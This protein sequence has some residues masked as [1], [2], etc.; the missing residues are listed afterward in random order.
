[1]LKELEI[2]EYIAPKTP[3]PLIDV[4]SPG[5][6]LKGH[7]PGAVNI[8]LFSNDERAHVGTVYKQQ[9]KEKAIE[10]GY[11][12][13]NPKLDDFIK[14]AREVAPDLNVVVHC[15]RG[16]MRSQSFAKHLNDN[17]FYASII[18]GGY[19]SYRNI[20]LNG[21][22]DDFRLLVLGGYTGSGK[23]P[24]LLRLKELGHQVI[25]LEGLAN[26]KGSAFGSIG[27]LPQPTPEQFENNLYWEWKDLD[28]S[29][30]IWLEDESNN[31]GH[32]AIQLQLFLKMRDAELL[33]LDIPKEK[34][35][36]HLI[37]DYDVHQ[38]DLLAEALERITKR[39]GGDRTRKAM[40]YLDNKDFYNVAII[41]L[42][43]Y[44]KYY[45]KGMKKREPEKI[46]MIKSDTTDC[47][48]NIK[49]ILEEI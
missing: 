44:D 25:D 24:I 41:C 38:T 1:M 23:T 43:Y 4:R 34:R 29:R 22:T 7:I 47:D 14:E 36:L 37:D 15:W 8:P 3:L 20:A 19:K 27:C 18:K 39:L 13:V 30:P 48:E 10:L 31:I 2:D 35:A 33:F 11:K 45:Y 6:F 12:Y 26:H 46:K 9:N 49:K 40:G 28:F 5:E 16:G 17:G 21:F 32:V 42:D